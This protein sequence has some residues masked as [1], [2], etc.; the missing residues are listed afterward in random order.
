[1]AVSGGLVIDD[2]TVLVEDGT[3]RCGTELT[4]VLVHAEEA[5]TV[6]RNI[7]QVVGGGDVAFSLNCCWIAH[8]LT[9]IRPDRRWHQ[10]LVV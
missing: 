8:R 3:G 6:D 10:S 4:T 5:A 7:Q 2:V 9:P 1:M